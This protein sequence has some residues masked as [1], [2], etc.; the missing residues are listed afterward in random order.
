MASKQVLGCEFKFPHERKYSPGLAPSSPVLIVL[1]CPPLKG[2]LK[3]NKYFI[4]SLSYHLIG[5]WERWLIALFEMGE[6]DF[7]VKFSDGVWVHR[8]L[9]LSLILSRLK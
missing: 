7:V 3:Y 8:S 5:S 6:T 9:P 4:S 1:K 2:V